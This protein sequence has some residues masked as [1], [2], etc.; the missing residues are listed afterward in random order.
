MELQLK[1]IG[2]LL[3][4]LALL[5][6]PFPRRFQWKSELSSLSLLNREMMYVHT[7]FIALTIL[8]MGALCLFCAGDLIN[9]TLGNRVCLGLAI[10]WG[11]RLA[12][13]FFG[14][15]SELWR[16]KKFET[17]VHVIFSIFWIYF[18]A[19]F[20]LVWFTAPSSAQL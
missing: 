2:G 5:H 18:T 14:Y 11:T 13:Q 20:F 1:I 19:V 16:G 15:S 12:V 7:L 3:I 8:L 17:V 6:I 10:F 4:G 9:T